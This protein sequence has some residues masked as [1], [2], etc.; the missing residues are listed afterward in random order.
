M[1]FTVKVVSET[2]FETQMQKLRDAGNEGQL[3][4]TY[5]ANSNLPGNGTSTID[6]DP[7]EEGSK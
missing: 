5:N 7:A 3:D 6:S 4:S 2:E 1:L